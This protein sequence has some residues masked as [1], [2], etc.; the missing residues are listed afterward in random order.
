MLSPCYFQLTRAINTGSLMQRIDLY[1]SAHGGLVGGSTAES[2]ALVN[3]RFAK[4]EET[5]R[6]EFL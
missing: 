6:K 1:K 4:V 5:I 3:E 2:V